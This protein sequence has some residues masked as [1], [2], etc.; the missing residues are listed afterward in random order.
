MY[1]LHKYYLHQ[2]VITK[3]FHTF[4]N[5]YFSQSSVTNKQSSTS[6]EDSC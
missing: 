5:S 4:L 3:S 6:D 1:V 2:G